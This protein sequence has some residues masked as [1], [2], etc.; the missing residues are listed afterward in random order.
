MYVILWSYRVKQNCIHT[1][2]EHYN[3]NG[4]WARLFQ[5][6][7]EYISTDLLQLEGEE[8]N[9]MTIDRWKSQQAYLRFKEAFA[10]SYAELDQLCD[11]LTH[12]EN[13]LGSYFTVGE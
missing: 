13:H 6:S 1:F 3:S 8:L 12:E 2:R 11:G 9:F 7:N 10:Q 4:T 5:Q